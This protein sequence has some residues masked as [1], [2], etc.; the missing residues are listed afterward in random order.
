MNSN[1]IVTSNNTY[2]YCKN[3]ILKDLILYNISGIEQNLD[4]TIYGHTQC[5]QIKNSDCT[6]NNTI[7]KDGESAT[8]FESSNSLS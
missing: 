1:T 6:I 7:I 8:F 5:Q 3:G 4:T 2:T